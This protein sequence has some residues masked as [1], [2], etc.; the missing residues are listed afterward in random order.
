MGCPI[1]H[2][3]SRKRCNIANAQKLKNISCSDFKLCIGNLP[4]KICLFD[5]FLHQ[6]G[7]I[8]LGRGINQGG[9]YFKYCSLEVVALQAVSKVKIWKGME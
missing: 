4:N 5:H 8:I 2:L 1:Q 3:F 9:D 7:V 6:K